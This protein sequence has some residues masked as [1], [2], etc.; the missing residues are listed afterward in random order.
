MSNVNRG[1]WILIGI[2]LGALGASS[3]AAVSAQP[4]D[5]KRL[6]VT[7]T[8]AGI[9]KAAFIQDTKSTGCWFVVANAGVAIAPAEACK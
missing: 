2:V 8:S 3:M 9:G 6:I 7:H 4:S 5:A 1:G